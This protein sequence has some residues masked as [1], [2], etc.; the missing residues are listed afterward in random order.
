MPND[1]DLLIRVDTKLESLTHEVRLMRDGAA[2]RL[3]YV[4]LNKLNIKIFEEYKEEVEEREKDHE[5]RMR[6]MERVIYGGIGGLAVVQFVVI[7]VLK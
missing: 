4:E 2:E 5:V 7:L 6:R 3:N 1:H